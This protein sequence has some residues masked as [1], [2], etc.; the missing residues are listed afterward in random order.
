MDKTNQTFDKLI[1][2]KDGSSFSEASF[3]IIGTL[4]VVFVLALIPVFTSGSYY[5]ASIVGAA[6]IL[7][8][9]RKRITIIDPTAKT[10]KQ[11]IA[12]FGIPIPKSQKA[13]S[14]H[15]VH[16]VA[17]K[18]YN[19]NFKSR[20]NIGYIPLSMDIMEYYIDA[21]LR[22]SDTSIRMHTS[23]SYDDALAFGKRVS[24]E[25]NLKLIDHIEKRDKKAAI[26]KKERQQRGLK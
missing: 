7:L 2:T 13:F 23:L 4:I 11:H 5:F 25:W 15:N 17:L 22:E 12:V 6:I 8:L 16:Y 1:I 24:T 10:I 18:F 19:G 9:A 14:S 3:R 20:N 26:K 21:K